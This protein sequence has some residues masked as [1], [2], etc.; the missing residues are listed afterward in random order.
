[1]NIKHAFNVPAEP[2]E[3]LQGVTIRWL[4]AEKDGAPHFA[5]RLF[6]VQPGA[7]TF[8]HTHSHEHELYI[9]S[10]QAVLRGKDGE[11]T[12][13]PN[14]TVFVPGDEEHQF[15]NA[16]QDVLRFLCAIPL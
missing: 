7:S 9:L 2:I 10:G 6:E 4:W 13:E 3:E 5:L 8:Y 14:D 12:L 11:R 16:G 15:V 1:M